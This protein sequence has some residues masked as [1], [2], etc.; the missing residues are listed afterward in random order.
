MLRWLPLLQGVFPEAVDVA[1][2][3]SSVGMKPEAGRNMVFTL[4]ESNLPTT[5][6]E[7]VAKLLIYLGRCREHRNWYTGKE[8]ID[9]LVQHDLPCDLEIGLEE[10]VAQHG[11]Q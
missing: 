1:I 4:N 8:L 5:Y 6:P 3:M 9:R 11:L 10:L 2:R 7:S